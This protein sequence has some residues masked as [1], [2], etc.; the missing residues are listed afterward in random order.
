MS[1]LPAGYEFIS[2]LE[3]GTEEL[4]QLLDDVVASNDPL[5]SGVI[6]SGAETMFID[7]TAD[8]EDIT[9][10]ALGM[11]NDRGDLIGYASATIDSRDKHGVIDCLVIHPANHGEGLG[12]ALT[13]EGLS[14]LARQGVK[15]VSFQPFGQVQLILPYIMG[16]YGFSYNELDHEYI[17]RNMPTSSGQKSEVAAET[18]DDF[19]G[20]VSKEHA[21]RQL[22]SDEMELFRDK[23]KELIQS[24]AQYAGFHNLD[25]EVYDYFEFELAGTLYVV[26]SYADSES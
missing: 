5:I 8:E 23:V 19:K 6:Q 10:T 7:I 12:R 16:N 13:D 17:T 21:G 26:S 22:N 2:E 11:R 9:Q 15:S 14:F 20:V 4:W 3:V 1:A 18:D 25:V 24:C